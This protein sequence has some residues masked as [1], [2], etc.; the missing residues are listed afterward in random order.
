MLH[1]ALFPGLGGN[2]AVGERSR[3]RERREGI[4]RETWGTI[5]RLYQSL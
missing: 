5:H 4:E 3:K 2:I 1:A